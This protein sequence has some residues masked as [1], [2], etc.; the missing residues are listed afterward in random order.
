MYENSRGSGMIRC[1]YEKR[2]LSF[3]DLKL[4]HNPHFAKYNGINRGWYIQYTVHFKL[5]YFFVKS[6]LWLC[7]PG[8]F[9]AIQIRQGNVSISM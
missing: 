9:P 7:S 4:E 2:E 1:I 8:N 5:L 3:E 6:N